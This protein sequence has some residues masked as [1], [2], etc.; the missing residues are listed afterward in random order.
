MRAPERNA[1]Q[2]LM[3]YIGMYRIYL[4]TYGRRL[5]E[6]R[7]DTFVAV[8]GGLLMQGS[9]VVFLGVV[10]KR[11]PVLNGFSHDELFFLFGFVTLGRE[12]SRM[13]FD[14]PFRVGFI[15]R[16]GQLD[17]F[18]IRPCST[19]FQVVAIDV[20]ANAIGGAITGLVVMIT[21]L[22][23]IPLSFGMGVWLVIAVLC[24]ALMQF[25]ILMS[26]GTLAFRL[27]EVN[28]ILLPVSW[29]YEFNRYPLTVFHPAMQIMLTYVLPFA[30]T[31]FFPVAFFLHPE[32]YAWVPVVI[33]LATAGMLWLAVH[34]WRK[35]LD[36]YSSANA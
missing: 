2:T 32:Q 30:V 6:Y 33:P 17:T 19:L 29:L 25:A 18:I 36:N 7:A 1:W 16:R 34:L 12:I 28:S 31:A 11:I 13:F 9:F 8:L 3:Y 15:I 10:Y 27:S 14:S 21:A 35:G 4:I 22:H 5:I 20:Q 24:N 26:I 23:N